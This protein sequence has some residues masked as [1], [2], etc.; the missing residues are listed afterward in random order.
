MA[1]PASPDAK[2]SE[3]EHTTA[4]AFWEAQRQPGWDW[5]GGA[6]ERGRGQELQRQGKGHKPVTR[7]RGDSPGPLRL[8][9]NFFLPPS[10]GGRLLRAGHLG[11]G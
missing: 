3:D 10:C 2:K 5:G 4:L 8:E 7:F 1:V 6:G 11:T 9:L